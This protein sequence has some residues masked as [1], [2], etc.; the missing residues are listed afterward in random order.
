MIETSGWFVK[1]TV[2]FIVD[3]TV[4]CTVLQIGQY[5]FLKD[6]SCTKSLNKLPL[7]YINKLISNKILVKYFSS[8]LILSYFIRIIVLF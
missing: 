5:F 7:H 8:T 3:H 6:F 4:V 1:C 2:V